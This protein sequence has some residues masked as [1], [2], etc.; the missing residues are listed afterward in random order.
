MTL[1]NSDKEITLIYNS[2]EQIGRKILA[3]AHAENIP[4]REIDLKHMKLTPTHWTELASK[5]RINVRDFVNTE[6][7]NFS[8]KFG[9]VDQL[10]D[11]DWLDLLIHNPDILKAPIVMKGDK[12][13]MMSNPQEMLYFVK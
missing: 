10:S 13:I 3:Y 4:I 5:M 8:Q 12:V 1:A 9:R 2:E 11:E 7:P 6:H